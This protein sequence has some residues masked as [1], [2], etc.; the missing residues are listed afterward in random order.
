MT[1]PLLDAAQAVSD[2]HGAG[3][4][5]GLQWGLR[6]VHADFTSSYGYRW[7]FPGRWAECNEPM[8]GFTCNGG[9]CPAEPGDGLCVATTWEGMASGGVPALTLL[10][11][12]WA[13]DDV[14]GSDINKVR[15]K[16]AFVRDVVDGAALARHGAGADLH[17][18][19]LHGANLAVA[20]LRGAYLRGADL[21]RVNL[22]CADLR[23]AHLAGARLRRADLTRAELRYADLAGADLRYADLYYADLSNANLRGADL[24]GA[25]LTG[26][27]LSEARTSRAD[28]TGAIGVTR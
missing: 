17:G 28:L 5:D 24:R 18:A 26:A 21:I 13:E 1:I 2:T 25:N 9:P 7:P 15:V 27:D 3:R 20:E 16:R 22:Y 12:G 4:P 14:L 6:A 10:L 8:G 19:D 11:V 23:D